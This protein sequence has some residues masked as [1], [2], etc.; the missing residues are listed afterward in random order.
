MRR[1]DLRFALMGTEAHL[2]CLGLDSGPDVLDRARGQL[3]D[4][5][6][7]WSRFLPDSELSEVNRAAGRPVIV[8]E[9]TYRL[10]DAAIQAW[11]W[12]GGH[13]DPTIGTTMEAAG[14]D[15]PMAELAALSAEEGHARSHRAAP[16]PVDIVLDPYPRSVT[17]PSGVKLD[18]GG[19]AKGAAADL[20]ADWL[21]STGAAGCCVNIGGDLRLAGVPPR[22]EGWQVT[23]DCPGGDGR[24]MVGVRDGAVCTSTRTKRTWPGPAGREHHLRDPRTGSPIDT[25]LASVTVISARALQ[26]EVLTKAAFAAGPAAAGDVVAETGAT[27]LLVTDDGT[28]VEMPGYDSFAAAAVATAGA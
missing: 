22:P 10:I 14:Y 27:G 21:L 13:F 18:L 24:R 16:T 26:A 17:V 9:E 23:L 11:H 8:S 1:H 6:R 3:D 20:V 12:S 25:G 2:I 4:L 15:R 7:R 5:E 19:I 28:V